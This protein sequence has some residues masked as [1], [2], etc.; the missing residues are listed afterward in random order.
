MC[1][2]ELT[3]DLYYLALLTFRE[4]H[5]SYELLHLL[6]VS[7]LGLHC[8]KTSMRSSFYLVELLVILDAI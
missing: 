6:S 3:L 2:G 8:N 7:W 5:W 4:C 1:L